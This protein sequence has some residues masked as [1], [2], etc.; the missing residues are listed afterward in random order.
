MHQDNEISVSDNVPRGNRYNQASLDHRVLWFNEKFNFAPKA[1]GSHVIDPRQLRGVVEN[2]IGAVQIPI[3]LAGPLHINGDQA[4]GVFFAPF[5]TVEGVI[6]LSASRGAKVINSSGGIR[7]KVFERQMIRAPIFQFRN[8]QECESFIQWVRTHEDTIKAECGKLSI[9]GK[10]E[11]IEE[12]II[13]NEVHLR[14]CFST[15]DAAGQNMVT[16]MTDNGCAWI[17]DNFE[18]NTGIRI[19]FYTV[20]GNLAGDKKINFLNFNSSRGARVFTEVFLKKEAFEQILK[21]STKQFMKAANTG[22]AGNIAAGTPGGLSVNSANV[23]AA[24]YAATG[25]DL[26]CVYE[27][28][29]QHIFYEEEQDGIYWSTTFPNI[30]TGT[31]SSA[32]R[33]PTQKECL[34]LLGCSQKQGATKLAEII[35]AFCVAL[36]ISTLAS[37]ANDTFSK[38]HRVFGRG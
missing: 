28:S 10:L 34:A 5:A 21:C 18:K 6:T 37:V 16:V 35:A 31:V 11:R 14:F 38:A 30:V 9:H 33:L 15:G 4:N 13:G 17:R 25:Q 20:E 36:D 27:S 29:A 22:N 19:R 23:I 12:S 8:L 26:G 1:L 7:V 3:G 32:Q 2:F 24:L